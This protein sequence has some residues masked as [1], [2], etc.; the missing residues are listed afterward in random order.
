MATHLLNNFTGQR[1]AFVG[2]FADSPYLAIVQR[3]AALVTLFKQMAH[4]LFN[5]RVG[6]NR[7]QTAKVSAV[8][9]FAKRLYLN[10]TNLTDVTVAANKNAAV[11]DDACSCPAVYAHQNRIFT[12]WLAP[13]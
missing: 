7:L 2:G 5:R 8:A 4:P 13:K 10:M 1:I 9:A 11:R 3:D 6:G 12:I